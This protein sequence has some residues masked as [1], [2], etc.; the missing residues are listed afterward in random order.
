MARVRDFR[1]EGPIDHR[2][3]PQGGEPERWADGQPTQPRKNRCG[4]PEQPL[5]PGLIV[6]S[7]I[8]PVKAEP[9]MQPMDDRWRGILRG[10][11]SL[12]IM[13]RLGRRLFALVPS[14]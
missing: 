4:S 12:A 14:P 10:E 8:H 6:E 9:P 11:T 3:R 5:H 7:T 13:P 1:D 2:R